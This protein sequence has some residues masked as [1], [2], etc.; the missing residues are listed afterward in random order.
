[1]RL[2][3]WLLAVALVTIAVWLPTQ[4]HQSSKPEM[5]T[6]T[7]TPTTVTVERVT[8][9][10]DFTIYTNVRDKK[11][12]FFSFL[13]PIVQAENAVIEQA[14][15]QLLALVQVHKQTGSLNKKQLKQ[16]ERIAN[17]YNV[18]VETNDLAATFGVLLRRVDV[19][20]EAL[21]LVQ[22]ANE[23]AWGTSRF[24]L[25]GLNFFGQWCF[26]K[27][28]GLVPDAR[29]EDM[30][31]EVRKFASVNA[32]VRSYLRNINTHPAYFELRR[33]RAEKRQSGADIRAL[34][35]TEGLMSYSERG[36]DY[37]HELNSMIRVNRPIIIDVLEPSSDSAPE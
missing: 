15:E 36:E 35:L 30:T 18:T 19:V 25:E 11:Q 7:S 9:V 21:A 33:L 29:S 26:R 23:S 20:P 8:V 3:G 34:D 24:A 32:S 14:R 16:L 13:A 22:A 17:D 5:S 2:L 4:L 28:C 6:D 37:I 10:P 1:M 31:H 12:A 27:G